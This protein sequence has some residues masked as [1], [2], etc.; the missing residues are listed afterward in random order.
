MLQMILHLFYL[1]A[2]KRFRYVFGLYKNEIRW[3]YSK[4]NTMKSWKF[5]LLKENMGRNGWNLR[6]NDKKKS[7]GYA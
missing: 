7:K 6:E 5:S 2:S 4:G 1:G 3:I